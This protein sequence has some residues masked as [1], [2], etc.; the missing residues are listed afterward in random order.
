M[1]TI[2]SNN[3]QLG[4]SVTATNN[5]T[6][7]Q[8][9]TPDGT[10]R[11]GVGNSGATTSDVVSVSSAGL[12]SLAL[13]PSGSTVPTNGLYL[14]TTNTVGWSTNSTER[15]RLDASGNLGLGVTSPTAKLDVVATN[16]AG[17]PVIGA[18]YNA[19]NARIGFNIGNA[20]GFAYIGYNTNNVVSSDNAT[21]DITQAASRLRMDS[22]AFKFDIAPSGTAGNAI[23]FTQAMTLDASGNLLVGNTATV[24]NARLYVTANGNNVA[25][26][27]YGSG[28]SDS[29]HVVYFDKPSATTSTSQVFVGFTVN[30]QATGNG[31]I[32]GNGA[33]AAAFGSFS[34]A[35]LKENITALP[36]QLANILALKPSEFDYKDGSGH[37]IGF[38]AQDMQ[39]VYPD[40][41]GEGDDGMLTITGWSKTEARLVKAIQELSQEIQDLK[42]KVNA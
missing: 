17:G 6:W 19:S 22:G 10:V 40:V 26:R 18:R 39:E 4:Q 30:A 35:R 32:N 5:F 15:M 3:C 36:N 38:I 28:L 25:A 7:Y 31:Q 41:V 8:P 37:Q 9:S 33:G 1:S 16:F 20:N 24:S 12:S 23:S 21:Y 11:L 29:Q 42:A 14:P 27:F 2:K 13:I 34:D